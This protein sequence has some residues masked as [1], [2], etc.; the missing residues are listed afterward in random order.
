MLNIR[1]LYTA[2]FGPIIPC[3]I[4]A[5]TSVGDNEDR[6]WEHKILAADCRGQLIEDDYDKFR[7]QPFTSGWF[8]PNGSFFPVC[9]ICL[10]QVTDLEIND[11]E[12]FGPQTICAECAQK[13]KAKAKADGDDDGDGDGVKYQLNDY[14]Q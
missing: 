5:I 3:T 9:D 8:K 7:I 1:A 13:A 10:S 12:T 4:V 14:D 6:A 2:M 11:S